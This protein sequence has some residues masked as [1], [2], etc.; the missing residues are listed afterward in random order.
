MSSKAKKNIV[1]KCPSCGDQFYYYDGEFRPFCSER[2]KNIDFGHWLN[3]TY[4]I[5]AQTP[6]SDEAIEQIEEDLS[7]RVELDDE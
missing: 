5:A 1:V 4:S 6:L 2:C 7:N 3:E